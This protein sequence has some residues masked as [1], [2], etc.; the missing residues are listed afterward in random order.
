MIKNTEMNYLRIPDFL[1]R[2]PTFINFIEKRTGL[3]EVKYF[4]SK[5]GKKKNFHFIDEV[6][7]YLDFTFSFSIKDKERI[8]RN[9]KLIIVANH[10]SGGL[11]GLILLRLV[12]EVRN[13]V[14]V[15]ANNKLL[16]LENL[17]DLFLPIDIVDKKNQIKN[18][19]EIGNSLKNDVA[20]IFFPA[21]EVSRFN[22]NR[23]KDKKW[24]DGVIK[25][26]LKYDCPILPIFIN[27]HNSP[28]FY[29]LSLISRKFSEYFLIK[30]LLKKKSKSFKIKVGDQIPADSFSNDRI[31]YKKN[32]ELL[33]RHTY[34]IDK[35]YRGVLKTEKNIIPPISKD[36]LKR[37]ISN[38]KVLG[39]THDHKKIFLTNQNESP[40]IIREIARLRELTFRKVGMGTGNKLDIDI[41]DG[42]YE[43]IVL[44]N[45]NDLEIIGSY[46][47]GLCKK[48]INNND[49]SNLYTSTLFNFSTSFNNIL[50]ESIE[51]GRSFIQPKYWNSKALDYLWQGIGAFLNNERDI[52]YM[53]GA[54]SLSNTYPQSAKEL[55]VFYLK[56]WFNQYSDLA[57]A[58]NKFEI[59]QSREEELLRYFSEDDFEL[60]MFKLKSFLK[61]TGYSIPTLIKHYLNLCEPGGVKFIDFSVDPL[62]KNCIDGLIFVEIDKIKEH[63]KNRY[64]KSSNEKA[65]DLSVE[66]IVG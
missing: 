39:E 62:F 41:Y 19:R 1:K 28:G 26:S 36:I 14:K 9:G 44:W 23:I 55:L 17:K 11:D 37:E 27:A 32:I 49:I 61:E 64:V 8:P 42:K 4:L 47:I 3:D 16:E 21:G 45:E 35:N 31:L 24:N 48:I 63:K 5:H 18:I 65:K 20:L 6:F 58:K 2:I 7:D 40:N 30:E 56:K 29:I 43:H 51:L 13:D 66:I 34:L 59:P 33:R 60:E 52:K 15:V 38:C 10:P 50:F 12:K 54:V 22:F 53:F 57:N 46:R 25:F